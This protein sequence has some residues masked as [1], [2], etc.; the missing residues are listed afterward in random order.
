M[1]ALS[2]WHILILLVPIVLIGGVVAIVLVV[3]KSGK[4]RPPAFPPGWY[5]DLTGAPIQRYWDGTK[6]TAQQ[7]LP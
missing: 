3:A 4:P 2:I 5:P 6:W 7:P 1:G